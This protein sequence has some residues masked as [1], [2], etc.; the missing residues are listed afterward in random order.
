MK[1]ICLVGLLNLLACDDQGG[2]GAAAADATADMRMP[3][4]RPIDASPPGF[5]GG[6]VCDEGEDCA[7]CFARI[8][9]CCYQDPSILGQ[10][11]RLAASCEARNACRACCREC[12][13]LAC[14]E[15]LARDNCPN[16][17][18]AE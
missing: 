9:E 13:A 14:A 4:A 8:G 5:P 6:C 11:P 3:D 10:A 7:A 1:W 15:I 17:L 18:R 16:G 2:P 12:A